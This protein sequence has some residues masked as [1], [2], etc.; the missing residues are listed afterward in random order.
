[1]PLTPAEIH[2]LRD[3]HQTA[4]K[5]ALCGQGGMFETVTEDVLGQ[6]M[7]VFAKRAHSI[8]DLVAASAQFSEQEFLVLENK[9]ITFTQTL[10]NVAS[11]A[12]ALKEDFGIRKGDRV[13]ILAANCP[14]W[15]FT[16]L[17]AVSVGA[18]VSAFNG[19]WTPAEIQYGL[20]HSTPK[21]LVG[22]TQRLE[23]VSKIE[24][25][26]AGGTNINIP[27]TNIPVVNIDGD[28]ASLLRYSPDETLPDDP[29]D[30]DDPA[31]IL[32]TSG[33]TGQPKGALVSHRGLVGFVQSTLCNAAIRAMADASLMKELAE[34]DTGNT[35][36]NTTSQG[37]APQPE[38]PATE[39][40]ITLGTSPLFHVSGLHAGLLIN[41][42]TGGKIVYRRGRFDPEEVLKLI[43]A[44]RITNFSPLGSMA[45]RI[46]RHPRFGEFDTSS[47]RIVGSGGAPASPALQKLLRESFPSTGGSL[48]IG[49][50]SSESTAV[51]ATI[52][53]A[54]YLDRPE[55]CG[56]VGVG[57]EVEIRDDQERLLPAG[58]EGEIHCRSAYTMLGYWENPEATAATLKAGGWLATGDI[59]HFDADGYLYINSRARDMILR[60]AE[61]IYPVEIEYRL[62]A[63]PDVEES[64]VLGVE[65]PDMGQEVKAVVVPI[66][67]RQV[68]QETLVE[69]CAET[70]APY[71]VPSL[72]EIRQESLPRNA[73]GKLLKTEL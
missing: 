36:S 67:G 60:N 34:R 51:V 9:R 28:F 8:R 11:I 6:P 3:A 31:L 35:T 20:Q 41:L 71:K 21:L 42:V 29:L 14:E 12:R 53:G 69:W 49:Y 70:L 7:E 65:H 10:H 15:V 2:Q 61:N 73:A 32:Y 27:D 1:M 33:T 68:S 39:Q 45:T 16:F 59:G 23:R 30:E 25:D 5:T 44:E 40:S 50:G 43:E 63:H 57:M 62:D 52:G 22:D 17:A 26:T 56:R 4:I 66:E 24:S 13:A 19:W 58:Q 64:A 18:I 46:V 72:W 38:Q 47:V 48:G 37:V 55:S 54:E